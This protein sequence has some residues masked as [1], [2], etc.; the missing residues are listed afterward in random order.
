MVCAFVLIAYYL[1]A[2]GSSRES[3][4]T[5]PTSSGVAPFNESV[6]Q[7]HLNK[8][9]NL[10]ERGAD[11]DYTDNAV[12]IWSGASLAY[13]GTY[14][15]PN[16]IRD[17]LN[18]VIGTSYSI[19]VSVR[20]FS[21]YSSPYS[22]VQNVNATLFLIGN[23]TI[24]GQ[25]TGNI[26][27]QYQFVYSGGKWQIS[28]E[29]WVYETFTTQFNA[30]MTTFPQWQLSGPPLPFRYSESP[31]KNWV[32]FYGGSAAAI[33]IAGYLASIPVFMRLRTKRSRPTF[34]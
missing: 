6:L 1:P 31:F 19:S 27:A 8:M 23:S 9:D 24:V 4:T 11:S 15:G 33:A 5:I 14:N 22:N 3:S 17:L 28:Q 21:V 34:V 18:T 7:A 32:Y 29:T 26:D 30:G 16:N 25:I 12:V 13:G 20:D 10:D 2:D